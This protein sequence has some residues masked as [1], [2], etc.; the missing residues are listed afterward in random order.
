MLSYEN[1]KTPGLVQ[2]I[3]KTSARE[4]SR[5]TQKKFEP[6][7]D[8][9]LKALMLQVDAIARHVGAPLVPEFVKAM[10]TREGIMQDHRARK[11]RA[12]PD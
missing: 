6:L 1:Q 7:R 3:K 2:V 4:V 10:E 11:A 5:E 9:Q 12:V 8:E